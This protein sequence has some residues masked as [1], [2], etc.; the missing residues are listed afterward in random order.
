MKPHIF[1]V[2][3]RIKR[4]SPIHRIVHLSALIKPEPKRSFYRLQLEQML[5]AEINKALRK[6]AA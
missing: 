4:L 3:N 5:K 1:Q 6:R 2:A